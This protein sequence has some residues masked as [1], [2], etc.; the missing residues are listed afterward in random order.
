MDVDNL[1]E[2]GPYSVT[3]GGELA[4][5]RLGP[6]RSDVFERMRL[7]DTLP[8]TDPEFGLGYQLGSADPLGGRIGW[9]LG[10]PIIAAQLALEKKLPFAVCA[11]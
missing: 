8:E 11:D 1:D 2:L 7:S 5:V 6:E 4:T 9:D 10:D 3:F